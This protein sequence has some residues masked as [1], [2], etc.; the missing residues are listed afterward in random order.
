MLKYKKRQ[1]HFQGKGGQIMDIYQ[2]LKKIKENIAPVG[3]SGY[4]ATITIDSIYKDF[5]GE[6]MLSISGEIFTK[7]ILEY[8]KHIFESSENEQCEETVF[9]YGYSDIQI[10]FDE[11]SILAKR[12][13]NNNF[14]EVGNDNLCYELEECKLLVELA[15]DNKYDCFIKHWNKNAAGK[16]FSI[17]FCSDSNIKANVY[18]CASPFLTKQTY[19]K[20]VD[21]SNEDLPTFTINKI[22]NSLDING[23][24]IPTSINVYNVGQGNFSIVKCEN[25]ESVAIDIGITKSEEHSPTYDDAIDEMKKLNSDIVIISHLDL[26]HILGVKYIPDEMFKKTWIISIHEKEN[27]TQSA[28]RTQSANR[29]LKY[30]LHYNPKNTYLIDDC[31][32][33]CYAFGGFTI[34]QGS[35]EKIGHC[36][37]INTGSLIVSISSK[38]KK[39]LLPGDCVYTRIPNALNGEYDFLVVPHHGCSLEGEYSIRN[40]SP[41]SSTSVAVISYGKNSFGHPSKDHICALCK[42]GF[43]LDKTYNKKIV[44]FKF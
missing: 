29:L 11:F 3:Q 10:S 33:F 18:F 34:R 19:L 32:N 17:E 14:C 23:E 6:T 25:K 30:L 13:F 28:K 42:Q 37:E 8:D 20:F 39:A 12:L 31:N 35:G 5:F 7:E 22:P 4:Y 15:Y 36:N 43:K 21:V 16:L 40:F 2:I 24:Y 1:K 41:A 26:D 27:C 44:T 9:F 38:G